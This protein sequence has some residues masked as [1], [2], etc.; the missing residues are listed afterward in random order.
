MSRLIIIGAGGHGKVA[1]DCAE[2]MQNFD[3]IE[4]L[5]VDTSNVRVA[6][7]WDLIGNA[8]DWMDFNHSDVSWF[9][10]IGNNQIR[11]KELERIID[12]G[13]QVATLVHPSAVVSPYSHFDVGTLICANSVIN[14][15][16]HIGVGCI[17]NTGCSIDHD[18]KIDDYVHIAPGCRLAGDIRVGTQSFL[19]IG[20][21]VIPGIKIG[22]SVQTGA[23]A[24]VVNDLPDGVLAVGVPAKIKNNK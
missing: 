12:S 21:V 4:F 13:A 11:R 16:T 14:P 7:T 17:L 20:S 6:D 9:V 5:D 18:N 1:A 19:G 15:F 8:N 2:A 3:S 23:G 24:V 22:E 10:A